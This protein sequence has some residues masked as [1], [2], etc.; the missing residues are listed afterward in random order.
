[1]ESNLINWI[2][3][4]LDNERLINLCEKLNP[5]IPG[6]R[7]G[8]FKKA[9]RTIIIKSIIGQKNKRELSISLKSIMDLSEEEDEF[10]GKNIDEI[11]QNISTSDS[12]KL[13]K[14]IIY[15]AVCDVEEFNK[16]ASSLVSKIDEN[17]IYTAAAIQ[18]DYGDL[19]QNYD[20]YIVTV[21]NENGYYNI[22][23]LYRIDKYNF[24]LVDNEREYPNYGSITINSSKKFSEKNYEMGSFLIC[25][26]NKNDL[27]E[28][29]NKR[30]FKING[31]KLIENHNIYNLNYENIYEIAELIEDVNDLTGFIYK[32]KIID[33]KNEPMGNTI[34]LK[35]DNY[36][37]G[38]FGYKSHDMGGG[39][40][41]DR[42]KN[43][44][45]VNKYPIE[46]NKKY[47]N[48]TEISNRYSSD[49]YIKIVY[50]YDMDK[51]VCTKM[52]TI[53]DQELLEVL[54][55]IIKSE[56]ISFS[57]N[58]IQ[59]IRSQIGSI[60]NNSLSE[61][62]RCRIKNLIKNTE[63][64]ENFI[65]NDLVEII[66]Y[67]LDDKDSGEKIVNKI[68][69]NN[70]ILRK[71]QKSKLVISKLEDA[72]K[73]LAAVQSE[74]KDFR[75]KDYRMLN[76]SIKSDTKE[77]LDR[78]KLI[79]KKIEDL[80]E[81]L[82]LY[83]DVDKL[84][85][86]KKK[87]Y[88]E[89]TDAK[90]RRNFLNEEGREL[91]NKTE[92]VKESLER[93]FKNIADKYADTPF[94]GM[95][96]DAILKS[97]AEWNKDLNRKNFQDEIVS[98]E[99]IGKYLN[100][101]SS[102]EKD[103][104]DYIY[105][106]IKEVRNYSRNDII[107]IMICLTQG[108][109]TIFAGEPGVGKTSLC[110]I[111][112]NSLGLYRKGKIYNRY[113]EISVEKGWT[114][115]RDLIGYYNPLTKSF[116]KNNKSLFNIFNILDCEYKNNVNDFPYYILLDEANLSSME[117]YWAD[118]M[119]VCDIDKNNRI[120]NLGEDYIFN[121]PKTLRF[122]ATINYDHTTEMLSPRLIDRA[123]IILL[124][125]SGENDTL[126]DDSNMK[127]TDDIIKF[128]DLEKC[129]AYKSSE[130]ELPDQVYTTLDEIYKMFTDNNISISPRIK[131]IMDRY[132]KVGINLFE[133][134]NTAAQEFVGL[135]Y[136]VAQKLLPKIDGQGEEY[137]KFLK[138]IESF[139]NNNNMI[140]CHNIVQHIINKGNSNMQYY[141]FFS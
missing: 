53:T 37:Y 85:K 95:I 137:E 128:E 48:I 23:P 47:F 3:N 81:K 74:I 58:E 115:K 129:F 44:Y 102:G 73:E 7:R 136:V 105:G 51:L 29:S 104:I 42:S 61:K 131:K 66:S 112:A 52:D 21:K 57:K 133:E 72:K 76:D 93:E 18:N 65:E 27:E 49:S 41:I 28:T 11:R 127:V 101:R 83:G 64:T 100:I 123:W 103:L 16:L 19:N 43:D 135:D 99:N 4:N 111:I 116:D 139:F 122:L 77:L 31:N 26:F 134:T 97:A 114:S 40:Y 60:V 107:N 130:N 121:I 36:I 34:Y 32:N 108:F 30:K 17:G 2:L 138:Q 113:T 15:L 96:A 89:V 118:F 94:D 124:D 125:S 14:Q 120:I 25:K 71:L 12:K 87:I 90:N 6:F 24:S 92:K 35:D 75:N 84:S 8:N 22:Y 119:N 13:L 132:L 63:I 126:C 54:R 5:R 68:L 86:E 20:K 9:P 62:R 110:N 117:Y 55:Q 59:S 33:I 80:S 39:Y 106:R 1:M 50:F 67:L 91:E 140:K 69:E 88:A 56:N 46:D 38:P 78:K 109:L 45:I 70:D 141:Q 79:E 10:K 82:N 98:E